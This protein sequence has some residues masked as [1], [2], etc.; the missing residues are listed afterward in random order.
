MLYKNS[1]KSKAAY[2]FAAVILSVLF[3]WMFGITPLC[4][5]DLW[6]Q[7]NVTGEPGTWERL[8]SSVKICAHHWTFDTGRLAN[9]ATAPFLNYLPRWVFAILSAGAVFIVFIRGISLAKVPWISG[10]SALWL[11]AV[12]FVFPWFDFL[13]TVV[14]A[15][16]YV[17]GISLGL[18]Y[19]YFYI[20]RNRG[21]CPSVLLLLFP[22]LTGWWHEG[23]SV[24]LICFIAAYMLSGRSKPT[25]KE[26][27][28]GVGLL[29]GIMIIMLMPAFRAS[30]EGRC[31]FNWIKSVW[32][33]TLINVVV[34]NI[35]F[36]FYLFTFVSGLCIRRIRDRIRSNPENFAFLT[37]A[38]VFGTVS[39]AIYLIYYNGPRTGAFCQLIC[40]IAMLRLLP[41]F[42]PSVG[43]NVAKGRMIFI[44]TTALCIVNMAA[45]IRIQTKL[46]REYNE[47]TELMQSAQCKK[48]G[49]LFYDVTPISFGI[50]A[51]KPTYMLLNSSYG[52][53]R[54]N[55]IPKALEEFEFNSS[56]V[57]HCRDKRLFVY[58]NYLIFKGNMPKERADVRLYASDGESI[59]S[60]LRYRPFITAKGDSA[61]LILPHTQQIR[62][63]FTVFDAEL[64]SDT[65]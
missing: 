58:R 4:A 15:A 45:S 2:I 31:Q 62:N 20:D 34:F 32:Y 16:N 9:M 11:L 18:L 24:P 13:F 43:R 35:I 49:Q 30:V 40:F 1:G 22:V 61:I 64:V 60:R 14:Y 63:S 42:F 47:A 36:Y 21:R 54:I 33:E 27:V 50:D 17:W 48:S 55:V 23:L 52:L 39:T 65:R 57:R 26:I 12:C 56:D 25:S 51:M 59:R 7:T 19:L 53:I 44:A 37:G 41:A 46:S 28:M 10:R 3:G 29:S 8:V 5:D 6:Y 38:L